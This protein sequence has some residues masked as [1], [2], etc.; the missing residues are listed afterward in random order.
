VVVYDIDFPRERHPHL[1][2]SASV[3]RLEPARPAL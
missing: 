3:Y 1:L 2:A